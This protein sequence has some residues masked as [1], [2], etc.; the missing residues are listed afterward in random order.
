[1][2]EFIEQFLEMM[3]AERGVANNSIL[4]Y[5]GDLLDFQKFLSQNNL[6]EL[7]IKA[8]NIRDWIEYLAGNGLQARSIN[9]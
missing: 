2:V 9:R 8:K 6:L 5:K 4:G 3:I 1:M 7:N